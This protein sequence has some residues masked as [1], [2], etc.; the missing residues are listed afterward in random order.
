MYAEAIIALI[1]LTAMEIVLGIDNIVFIAILVARLPEHQRAKARFIGLSLALIARVA[2]LFSISWILS[3]NEPIFS[4]TDLG[5]PESWLPE[6]A[7]EAEEVNH[8]SVRDLILLVGGLFLLAKAVHEIHVK[9]EGQEGSR[10]ITS[11]ASFG[12]VL[13]QIALLDVVFSI[14]SV[15]TAVGMAK[16]IEVMVAAVII[17]IIVMMI[18]AGRV[19]RFVESRP[20]VKMLALS[21]LLLIG[22]MLIAESIGTPIDKGYI[23]FAMAFALLVEFLNLKVRGRTLRP[24]DGK[25][26]I[27]S[28]V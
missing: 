8:V 23:Y 14:D 6:A 25:A 11:H 20:T 22:V 19:S 13:V 4:F 2:L 7:E 12:S 1:A 24:L 26:K 16:Q 10:E 21:F 17:A 15:I 27:E 28:V 5:L 3:L 18:F 9:L